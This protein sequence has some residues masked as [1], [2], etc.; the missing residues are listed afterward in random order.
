MTL[1]KTRKIQKLKII[2]YYILSSLMYIHR[3]NF[4]LYTYVYIGVEA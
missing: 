2:I 3:P 4:G 1:T